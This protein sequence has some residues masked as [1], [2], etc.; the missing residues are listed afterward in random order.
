VKDG[1]RHLDGHCFIRIAT[2]VAGVEALFFRAPPLP[3][4]P[5]MVSPIRSCSASLRCAPRRSRHQR[6]EVPTQE[7][8]E[9][10]AHAILNALLERETINYKSLSKL[11][12]QRCV[13]STPRGA[14]E[15][16]LRGSFQFTFFMQV[17]VALGVEPGEISIALTLPR[18]AMKGSRSA[19]ELPGQRQKGEARRGR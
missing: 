3:E 18:P 13:C 1:V 4:F 17:L 9:E 11:L 19:T 15:K 5:W 14:K 7:E 8:W 12:S 10:E 16:I 2:H 6:G